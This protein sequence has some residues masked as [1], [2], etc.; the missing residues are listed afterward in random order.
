MARIRTLKPELPQS[1]SLG[2]VSRDARL[3][4]LLLFTVVDDSGRTRGSSR[5]LASVLF[6]YD[7]DA[8]ALI[9]EWLDELDREGCTRRYVIEGQT[10]L[11]IPKWL[12]H[13]RIDKPTDSKL[14]KF[15]ESS[16][17][18][19]ST[20]GG[21]VKDSK[22]SVMEGN[23]KEVTPAAPSRRHGEITKAKTA[24]AW[25]AYSTAYHAR[26]QVPPTPNAK[27]YSQLSHFIDRV[28]FIDAPKIAAFYVKH[29]KAYYVS[30]QHPV[31]LLLSDAE[32]LRTQWLSGKTVTETEARHA[33]KKQSNL[34]V[35]EKLIAEARASAK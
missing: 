27:V 26:Y 12:N 22:G 5:M 32:G 19:A 15:D 2:R 25:A 23:G 14:P 24:E 18:V 30:R 35:A 4:F 9:D 33:D 10:Y 31:G 1:E 11:D 21:I 34:G 13:Q 20:P 16:R 3:L 17:I 8:P 28:G 7:D 29:N 6:P